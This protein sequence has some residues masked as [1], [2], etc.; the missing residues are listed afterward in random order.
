MF[1]QEEKTRSQ[2]FR[3]LH[4]KPYDTAKDYEAAGFDPA[5]AG[6]NAYMGA[7][8]HHIQPAGDV[9]AGHIPFTYAFTRPNNNTNRVG[10][11]YKIYKP[12]PGAD[13]YSDVGSTSFTVYPE[14]L[15]NYRYG[16]ALREATASYRQQPLT[17]QQLM[18][19]QAGDNSYL[20]KLLTH[21]KS[22]DPA[23]W[24]SAN[25]RLSYPTEIEKWKESVPG[26]WPEI[27]ESSRYDP[28]ADNIALTS[29]ELR[30]EAYDSHVGN[31]GEDLTDSPRFIARPSSAGSSLF[32]ARH[33]PDAA[34]ADAFFHELN[35]RN[36]I[37]NIRVV[38]APYKHVMGTSVKDGGIA[39]LMR[40]E[41]QK[42]LYLTPTQQR[43][44]TGHN[45]EPY[46][47]NENEMNQA[48]LSFNAGRYRLQKDMQENPDNPNYAQIAPS[49]R[50]QF[51]SFTQFLQPGEAGAKQLDE[52]MTFYDQNPQFITM[53]PE[54]ARLVGYYKN[55]KAAIE[56]SEDPV[57]KEFFQ[58]MMNRMIYNKAFLANSQR[59]N[60]NQ[61]K[62]ASYTEFKKQAAL[63]AFVAPGLV[64]A[65]GLYLGLDSV[66]ALKKK[67]LLR[68]MLATA[69]GL[70]VSGS[71]YGLQ[72]L[73]TPN[74]V[75]IKD[76]IHSQ[77]EDW[78]R[79]ELKR[80]LMSD[81]SGQPYQSECFGTKNR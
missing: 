61:P 12:G 33:T 9:G 8:P 47:V 1:P 7:L 65:G 48:L 75:G 74:I 71:I 19:M 56:N 62:V 10:W 11:D 66:P 42:G 28:V 63:G 60:S 6:D 57:E 43:W 31:S 36:S 23:Y 76:H 46:A 78:K 17:T 14:H 39:T 50:Q 5:M 80:Y 45:I 3:D 67:R 44:I 58:G 18:A 32:S 35:H 38:D 25:L 41:T 73:V 20:D 24:R 40:P 34:D 79:N 69:G 52:L 81:E 16:R 27:N 54:Q 68:A 55:L 21:Y 72:K 30:L 70:G 15:P 37:G 26:M 59:S 22:I 49:V 77:Y 2:A 29:N 4:V 13:N 64:T 53:M 51:A